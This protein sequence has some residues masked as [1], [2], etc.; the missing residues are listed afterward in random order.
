MFYE[1]IFKDSLD[2]SWES[3]PGKKV[4]IN[5]IDYLFNNKKITQSSKIMDIGCGNGFLLNKIHELFN[6]G[7]ENLYGI[8]ISDIAIEIAKKEY[9]LNNLIAMDVNKYSKDSKFNLVFSYESLEHVID[10]EKLFNVITRILEIS[11][12]FIFMIPTLGYYRVD[13]EDEGWYEDLDINKQLQWNRYR[14]HWEEF[15]GGNNL[16]LMDVNESIKFG[17]IKPGNFYFGKKVR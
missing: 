16:K 3:A 7:K 13:R 1:K 5:Y 10:S 8:D 4:L 14:K 2:K 6:I 12:I 15:F 11:G 17:A 9:G